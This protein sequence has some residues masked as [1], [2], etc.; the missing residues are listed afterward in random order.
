MLFNK[1]SVENGCGAVVAVVCCDVGGK[2]AVN[3]GD[4]PNDG[5]GGFGI[6]GRF[7]DPCT[8]FVD[9]DDD[10]LESG[11]QEDEPN[12]LGVF[13]YVKL[14]TEY[15]DEVIGWA[16]AEL[17]VVINDGDIVAVTDGITGELSVD[18]FADK[19]PTLEEEEV[20][21]IFN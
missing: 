17:K 9:V 10:T 19:L 14:E 5:P 1:D 20:V 21:I 6:L 15:V 8:R 16:L 13:G 4:D 7:K 3:R 12:K 11:D 2:G 18:G